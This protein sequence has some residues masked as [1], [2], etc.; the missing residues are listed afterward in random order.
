[1][2]LILINTNEYFV[3]Y[4]M[5]FNDN[6]NIVMNLNRKYLNRVLFIRDS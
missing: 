6:I 1:M 4:F 2:L 5:A 3:N